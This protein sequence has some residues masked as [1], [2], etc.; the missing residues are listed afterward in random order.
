MSQLSLSRWLKF[1]IIL[2]A[3]CALAIYLG[4]FPILGRNIALLNPEFS[5]CFWPWLIF[6]WSTAIP[7]YTA[8]GFCWAVAANIG[9]GNSFCMANARHLRSIAV[10]AAIDS[11]WFLAGNAVLLCLNMSH[12]GVAL[13]SVIVVAFGIAVSVAAAVLSHLV[14]KAAVLQEQDDLTI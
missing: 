6:I 12:P 1:I 7:C 10:L 14:Q 13:G 4:M 11:V 8:L 3:V 2:V 5:Y 9:R